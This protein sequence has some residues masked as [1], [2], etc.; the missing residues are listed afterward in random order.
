MGCRRN[1][2]QFDP[3]T[4]V[5]S[6]QD[7]DGNLQMVDLDQVIL[8]KA[9]DDLTFDA[10]S[11]TLQYTN[12]L[13]ESKVLSLQA[14]IDKVMVEEP[15]QYTL[16]YDTAT[17]Q[18]SLCDL[19]TGAIVSV[20]Q[21]NCATISWD[22][23]TC[24]LTY[25][26]EKGTTT[27]MQLPRS[28]VDAR[29]NAAT[30][31][32]TFERCD[33]SV[34]ELDLGTDSFSSD[35][36]SSTITHRAVDGSQVVV[37]ICQLAERCKPSLSSTTQ[38]TGV[39]TVI[40]NDGYGGISTFDIPAVVVD[41][42][43]L[44]VNGTTVTFTGDNGTVIFDVCN[45]VANNCN[46]RFTSINS[47]GTWSFVDNAGNNYD[48]TP[49]V[50][51]VTVLVD[52]GD[53]F[54]Y[55][56]ENGAVVT[57]D[58][59]C[60]NVTE[61]ADNYYITDHDG[62]RAEVCKTPLKDVISVDSSIT[63]ST[64]AE[65]VRDLSVNFPVIPDDLL[66]VISDL[67]D[68]FSYLD[69]QG[70]VVVVDKCCTDVTED[71]DNYYVEDH[72]GNRATV[73][74]EPLKQITSA[75]GSAT[76]TTTT[77]GV[78]DV[79]V[80]FPPG[81]DDVLT[82][83]TDADES[84]TYRDE[85]GNTVTVD[86]CC[87]DVTED[88]DSYFI[89]DHNGNVAEVCK[90]PVKSVG[91][92]GGTA[93]ITDDGNGNVNIEVPAAAQIEVV[94]GTGVSVAR[95][96]NTYT[97]SANSVNVPTVPT[98]VDKNGNDI[99]DGAEL[100]QASD[101]TR[102][103]SD[104]PT[105]GTH[106]LAFTANGECIAYLPRDL[107]SV[108]SGD[109]NVTVTEV[110]GVYTVSVNQPDPTTVSSGSA[111]V[112]V[113]RTNDDFEVSVSDPRIVNGAGTVLAADQGPASDS[114]CVQEPLLDCAGVPLAKDAQVL[115]P[116]NVPSAWP[117][118][119]DILEQGRAVYKGP[120]DQLY[121]DPEYCEYEGVWGVNATRFTF[122]LTDITDPANSEVFGP[123]VSFDITNTDLCRPMWIRHQIAI[124]VFTWQTQG[125]AVTTH[126]D[127]YF[128]EGDG[129]LSLVTQNFSTQ[130]SN[131][132]DQP[133]VQNQNT[134]SRQLRSTQ[135]PAGTT[136]TCRVQLAMRQFSAGGAALP[137]DAA[138]AIAQPRAI[139]TSVGTSI[140]NNITKSA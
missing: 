67:G 101:F 108:V 43:T 121:V 120:D 63:V 33:G 29:F 66:T 60:T 75:D 91:S 99:A 45:L 7:D 100:L 79:S 23:A 129:V 81:T 133:A 53:T 98:Y 125:R 82:V 78:R 55:T 86:K 4:C 116:D 6:W 88:D 138:F 25:V 103:N 39:Q 58:K 127:I 31:A 34:V 126:T 13:G 69:E 47:D 109:A 73:C 19:T 96:G 114:F 15:S 65:G 52:N 128:D 9:Q 36:A 16:K 107:P 12:V 11:C 40:F 41:M 71:D 97:V 131:N 76:I 119:C 48:Y 135:I 104:V 132:T 46:A 115:M 57:V 59:C 84:F 30:R 21:I 106:L 94:A 42:D 28:M 3:S 72:N 90:A 2:L 124:D 26:D 93:T 8:N 37:D 17:H 56:N 64:V 68:S 61:D 62:N 134:L 24:R 74:K 137:T 83:L 50:E 54:S 5:L 49:P 70:N 110:D 27:A 118:A 139:M 105:D 89:T 87:T 22:S 80:N 20:V 85:Q 35:I 32:L 111:N 38:A 117:Y 102:T 136:L 122:D 51:N 113:V 77:T 18:A 95:S 123:I 130:Q 44:E 92:A 14:I 1:T 112:S 10:A 140:R